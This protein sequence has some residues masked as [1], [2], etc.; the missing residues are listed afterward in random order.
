MELYFYSLYSIFYEKLLNLYKHNFV[1]PKDIETHILKI[2]NEKPN[3]LLLNKDKQ[4]EEK[5]ILLD[6]KLEYI[7]Y[8]YGSFNERLRNIS[9][10]IR[11]THQNFCKRFNVNQLKEEKEILL[12]T[13]YLFFLSFYE[14]KDDGFDYVNIWNDIFV[15]LPI[16]EK[17]EIAKSFSKNYNNF[18]INDNT[19]IVNKID[20]E[21]T[22][23][24]EN[25]DDYSFL[26]LV[27][28]LFKINHNPNLIEL[29]KF[30]KVDKY[31]D[32]LYIRKIWKNWEQFLI[33]LFSS[34]V[35]K[36]LFYRIFDNIN[37]KN[38][39][40]PYYF[41][42]ENE[43]KTI[44]NNIRYNIFESNFYGTTLEGNLLIYENGDPYLIK[45]DALLSKIVYLCINVQ[46]NLHE[47][48]GNLNISF[49]FFLSKDERYLKLNPENP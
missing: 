43:I 26:P 3:L 45:N 35:I 21:V 33:K 11:K 27:N 34:N 18:K 19:L 23:S 39:L 5:I 16:E 49:Q 8:L 30:L 32:K 13:D 46:S 22:Y 38:K 24:I 36:S 20:E 40:I 7:P 10:F 12:I 15:D 25:I 29:N 1:S 42:N 6:K 4:N 37:E 44:I 2:I 9:N 47:I 17:N 14:F 28:L 31:M 41:I 48:M